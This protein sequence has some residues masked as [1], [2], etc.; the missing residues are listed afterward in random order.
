MKLFAAFCLL[1]LIGCHATQQSTVLPTQPQLL[2]STPLPP[3]TSPTA[4]LGLKLNVMFRILSDG[5][6]GEVNLLTPSGDPKWDT[7][8]LRSMK[9]W[10]FTRIHHD[11]GPA[12]TWVRYPVLVQPQIKEPVVMTLGELSAATEREAD[13]L[14]TLIENGADFDAL[15]LNAPG[16]SAGDQK[17]YL[18]TLDIAS[19]PSA[20]RDDLRRLREE[21]V[22]RPLRVDNRFVIYKRYRDE[23][24]RR[25]Q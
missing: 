10:R 3:L 24:S 16:T 1:T 21:E 11:G 14:Y 2:R 8:A 12:E 13:S 4:V 7:L 18:R 6:V 20:V 15:A 25:V 19:Y 5:T 9:Q 17:S 22:T 23:A